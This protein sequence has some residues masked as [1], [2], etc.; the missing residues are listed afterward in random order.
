MTGKKEISFIIT[1]D[2][3]LVITVPLPVSP[4]DVDEAVKSVRELMAQY[5]KNK[6]KLYDS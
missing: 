3:R 2:G 4:E 6:S 1:Q 5:I